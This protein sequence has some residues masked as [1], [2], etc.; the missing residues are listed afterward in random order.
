VIVIERLLAKDPAD[1]YDSTRDPYRELRQIRD[2]KSPR[3]QV[4]AT[5]CSRAVAG[6]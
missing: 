4:T 6:R 1:R 2:Q 5:A 3:T